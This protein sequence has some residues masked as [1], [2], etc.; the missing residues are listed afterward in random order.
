LYGQEKGDVNEDGVVNIID[1]LMIAQYYVGL[2]PPG[3]NSTLADVNSDGVVNIVDALIVAQY[4]VELIT[5]FP[6]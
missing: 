3:F 1:A 4:D 5:T 2:D 6:E